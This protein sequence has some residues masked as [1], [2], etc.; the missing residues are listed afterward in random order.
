M[1]DAIRP[2]GQSCLDYRIAA[3]LKGAVG[4]RGEGTIFEDKVLAIAERLGA[5]DAATDETEVAGIPPK[6]LA[7]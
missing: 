1:S 3:F 5:G 2:N 4:I 6:V 7:I